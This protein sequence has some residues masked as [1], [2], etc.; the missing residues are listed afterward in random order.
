MVSGMVALS[1]GKFS[2]NDRL[3]FYVEATDSGAEPLSSRAEVIVTV[4]PK[5][6]QPP[7]WLEGDDVITV[8][9]MYDR[10]NEPIVIRVA[11][12][13]ERWEYL[14]EPTNAGLA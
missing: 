6:K 1:Q 2:V 4:A 14:H 5:D 8:P 10:F 11:E 3:Q 7:R 12:R 9:E 13:G